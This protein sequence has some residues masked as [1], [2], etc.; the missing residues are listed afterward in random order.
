MVN[1]STIYGDKHGKMQPCIVPTTGLKDDGLDPPLLHISTY[2][3]NLSAGQT[4]IS[5][6]EEQTIQI[7][8]ILQIL[9]CK[10]RRLFR[11]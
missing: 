11:K 9:Y 3:M 5:C 1:M 7:A 2:S 8:D 4:E 6:V 10:I